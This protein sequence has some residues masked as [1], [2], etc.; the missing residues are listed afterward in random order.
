MPEHKI[1][2]STMKLEYAFEIYTHT[3]THTHTH[4][5]MRNTGFYLPKPH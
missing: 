3:H 4:T 5:Q 2:C 1:A